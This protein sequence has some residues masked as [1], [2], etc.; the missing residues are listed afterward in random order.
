MELRDALIPAFVQDFK[1]D[2]DTQSLSDVFG[3]YRQIVTGRRISLTIELQPRND[4]ELN[5]LVQSMQE[6]GNR[7]A[8]VPDSSPIMHPNALTEQ[9]MSAPCKTDQPKTKESA[10]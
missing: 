3:T 7:I 6:N 4:A 2:V 9:A 8:L 1:V 5:W 10:W